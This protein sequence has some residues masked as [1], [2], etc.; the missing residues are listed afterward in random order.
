MQLMRAAL[1]FCYPVPDMV[2]DCFSWLQT[3]VLYNISP[4][5][6]TD[7]IIIP[8]FLSEPDFWLDL[9]KL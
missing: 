5:N 8:K 3:R 4:A 1:S 2:I 6:A 9:T 7:P